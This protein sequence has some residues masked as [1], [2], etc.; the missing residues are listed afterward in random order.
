M[1]LWAARQKIH[2]ELA[3]VPELLRVR[4]ERLRK[5]GFDIALALDEARLLRTPA[6][7][8]WQH[9]KAAIAWRR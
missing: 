1:S 4:H 7:T 6:L 9:V 8:R 3:D 2:E 5:I